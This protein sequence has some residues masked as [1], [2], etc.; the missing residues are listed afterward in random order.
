MKHIFNENNIQQNLSSGEK[1]NGKN[2]IA[3]LDEDSSVQESF[4][5]L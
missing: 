4:I 2:S 5:T 3:V 1:R